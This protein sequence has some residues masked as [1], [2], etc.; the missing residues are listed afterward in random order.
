MFNVVTFCSTP[1]ASEISATKSTSNTR[2]LES[3]LGVSNAPEED[4]FSLLHRWKAGTCSGILD[5]PTF[6]DWEQSPR[7]CVLW[8]YAQPGSGKSIQAAFLINHFLQKGHRCQYFF[9]QHGNSSKQSP[10]DLLKSLA[11][12]VAQD[13][14]EFQD[15][16]NIMGDKGVRLDKMDSWSIWQKLF[17][18]T[19]F[20]LSSNTPLYWVIDALDES[21]SQLA[22]IDYLKNLASSKTIIHVL[23]TSRQNPAIKTAF[24][25]AAAG[26]TVRSL[27]LDNNEND[28][29]HYATSEQ[30]FMR[31]SPNFRQQ[32][33]DE[34][35]DRAGGSFLWVHLVLKEIFQC[36]SESDI[37]E[38]LE[39]VPS[40]MKDLYRRMAKTINRLKRPSDVSLARSILAWATYSRRSLDTEELLEA[41]R[42]E[43]PRILDIAET[44]DQVCGH[45]VKIDK[46]DNK[47]YVSL[48]HYTA[49]EYLIN[50]SGISFFLDP[51]A[52]HEK[53]F[54]RTLSIFIHRNLRTRLSEEPWPPLYA[55]SAT[56][57]GFH[58]GRS[59]DESEHALEL[60]TKFFSGGFVLPWIQALAILG[61]LK[62][63][64]YTSQN[65]A[66]FAR[67]YQGFYAKR[68]SLNS[69]LADFELLELWAIDLLKIVGKFGGFLLQDPTAIYKY[70]P[71][72]CPQN[73][74][75][76][77]QFGHLRSSPLRV[78][79][80][81]NTEW[82]DCLARLS[83]GS[84]HEAL[85]IRCFG[86]FLAIL[87][88]TGTT[89]LWDSRSFEE[90]RTF[91]HQ[92][93][94]HN[95]CFSN[96][97][98]MLASYGDKSTKIWNTS[99][100]QLLY[101]TASPPHTRPLDLRFSDF[102][103]VLVAG[104]ITRK[105]IRLDLAEVARG[106]QF[107][108]SSIFQEDETI[109]GTNSNSPNDM[110]FSPDMTQV[111]VAYR[112]YPLSVWTLK[113]PRLLGRCKRRIGTGHPS[114]KSW[115]GVSVVR[116]HP[117]NGHV[118]GIYVDGAVFKWHPLETTHEELRVDTSEATPSELDISPNGSVF[119]TS[120]VDGTVKLY[121]FH[122]F[123]LIYQLSSE[124]LITA[125]CFSP[126]GR[127][128]Y[129]IRGS[130]CNVWEPNSLI[131]ISD[132]DDQGHETDTW[133]ESMKSVSF[134]ASES[135][136]E[137][138]IPI[139]ALSARRQG[140]LLCFGNIKGAVELET[141]ATAEKVQ[142]ATSQAG[143][144][145]EHLIWAE[146][147]IH[148]AFV[149][150]GGRIVVKRAK[151][152][153]NNKWEISSVMNE[154]F[155]VQ[156]GGAHRLLISPDSKYV[157]VTSPESAQLWS[158]KRL[159]VRGAYISSSPGPVAW[160]NHPLEPSQI[161]V[162]SSSMV[163]S[164]TWST[165]GRICQWQIE[166]S[167]YSSPSDTDDDSRF[168]QHSVLEQL[169]LE[170]EHE[171]V[172]KV[173]VSHSK[174]FILLFISRTKQYGRTRNRLHIIEAS[175]L[176]NPSGTDGK[177]LKT[178]AI[179]TDIASSIERPLEVLSNGRLVFLDE[180]FWVCSW[181]IHNPGGP[182]ALMRHFFL[183]RDWVNAESLE[184]CQV[185]ANG[186]FLCPRKGEVAIIHSDLGSDW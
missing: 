45:F 25:R 4:Y 113:S 129:D 177:S 48:V 35:V 50:T 106:W 178:I 96:Q 175:S 79:G 57:W 28:I 186:T 180:S 116:W 119:V 22:V 151:E 56:S 80:L 37:K 132:S 31:G 93:H 169:D 43:H 77:R 78:E 184:L 117:R 44:I 62:Y 102:D 16:L 174:N 81:S 55:Y 63:L 147:G 144:V 20:G 145:V 100:G 141:I 146:D 21:D 166:P 10:G 61:E 66:N 82:D 34:L 86:R 170:G 89:I 39:E 29:R 83:V 111:A 109:P 42:P 167:P 156:K 121:S 24:D 154:S 143:M 8:M 173:I 23:V 64:V 71:Q 47:N 118:L 12:Q 90:I 49:R 2:R 3:I 112:G 125:I 26:I 183:P 97:G 52:A 92:E 84:N 139:T 164:L 107:G 148:F 54:N 160:A 94:V 15:M 1:L 30:Q 18:S 181:R 5:T 33:V 136:V 182:S 115:T 68:L 69:H 95:I 105:F 153:E 99:D 163:T 19:L 138:L 157:L 162:F 41:L 53:L 161:L 155:N 114:R 17:V 176:A 59:S 67:Q 11:F 185:T 101:V 158:I 46:R 51:E 60:M 123:T 87:I 171:S 134:D 6:I 128:F 104:L 85:L 88:S 36:H 140:D 13:V 135:H 179:P 126:D 122:H 142:K 150:L 165:L 98:E 130:Y 32:I 133:A 27:S 120:D 127:R 74:K 149:D 152:K 73:S 76:Y 168:L 65:I 172:K 108:P 124:D 7:S 75:L 14:Q 40:G 9:F 137:S 131:R 110:A 103:S 38:V 159:T 70:I 58:L 91:V 72:F